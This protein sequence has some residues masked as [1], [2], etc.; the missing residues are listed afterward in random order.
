MSNPSTIKPLLKIGQAAKLLGVSID[1]LRRWEKAGKITAIRT[2]GGTRLYSLTAL[3]KVNPSASWRIADFQAKDKTTE[4]LLASQGQA[5]QNPFSVIARNEVTWQ[6]SPTMKDSSP[7][8]PDQNDNFKRSFVTKFLIGSAF[9]S[10]I[11]LLITSWITASYL[12]NPNQTRQFFKNN[13]ASGLFSPFHKLA[14]VAVAEISPAQAKILGFIPPDEPPPLIISQQPNKSS[15]VLAVTSL[16]PFLEVNADTQINGSLFVR[17]SVNGLNMEATSS[18]STMALTS[19]DTTLTVTKDALLDQDVST[20]AAPTFNTLNLS[21]TKDQLVF[22][23]G[24]PAGTL[25][26][27]PTAAR[28]ITLPDT[29]TTLIGKD[30]T[31][32]LTNKSISGSSNTL[33][34]IPNSA[35][36]NSKVTVTA[37]TN[38]TGGGDISLGSSAT[39][40]LK[41]SPSIT[42]TLTVTGATTLSSTLTVSGA[43]ILSST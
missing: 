41:D 9:L 34:N 36:T 11:T 4:E 28:T 7:A 2:P 10:V 5:L 12:T 20:T 43:T 27:T 32:T 18:A 3:K 40:A 22:Q 16:L 21:A 33:T 31:D 29:T 42:G 35:L 39:I 14:E 38:L 15:A 1:T 13:I 26:W 17:D 6:S 37:G 30:T 8:K 23:S 19:G 24:G 25:T